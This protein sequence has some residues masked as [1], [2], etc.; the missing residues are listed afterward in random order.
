MITV[1]ITGGLGNQ[2]FQ[3][4]AG[5]TLSLQHQTE[6]LLD[7]AGF[8]DDRLRNF[9]LKAFET[10]VAFAEA[11]DTVFVGSRSF[12]EKVRDNIAPYHLRKVFR[13]KHFHFYRNFFKLPN[14]IYLKGYWQSEQYFSPA[15]DTIRRELQLKE[16]LIQKV[17]RF[18]QGLAKMNSVSV[19]VRRGD[20]TNPEVLRVHGVLPA[21]Y[22][23][24]AV[25]T[26][27]QSDPSVSFFVF[28][29]DPDWVKA[30]I[31]IKN[32]HFVSGSESTTHYEDFYLMSKCRHHIIANSSFSW[33]AA[34][35]NNNPDKK[36][37]APRQ[38]FN[39]GPKDT[40]D[41]IPRGWTA[42]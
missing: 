30:N 40:Q 2:L 33:W 9:E 27:L 15:A 28:T 39:E 8:N 19:H 26:F 12:L 31:R 17:A 13:E 34:W 38:W 22:Y 36:V 3:Y 41:L 10:N 23:D 16:P 18:G 29:D 25:S 14:G 24:K 35:L 6:L 20:Y 1:K 4:A 21:S 32:A 11:K 42:L 7:V 37:V 5:R